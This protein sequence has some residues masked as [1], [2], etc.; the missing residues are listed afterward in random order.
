MDGWV[1]PEAVLPEG[2]G[3][4]TTAHRTARGT[5]STRA[6]LCQ[7]G[8]SRGGVSRVWFTVSPN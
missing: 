4:V 6:R 1:L 5:A 3:E 8:P 7:G 2:Q